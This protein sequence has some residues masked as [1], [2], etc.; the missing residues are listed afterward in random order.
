[1]NDADNFMYIINGNFNF[2]N[3]TQDKNTSI[4]MQVEDEL[5]FLPMIWATVLKAALKVLPCW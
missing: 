5:F 1:M 4:Q 2:I 3:T